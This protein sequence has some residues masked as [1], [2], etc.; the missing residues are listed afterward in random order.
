MVVYHQLKR[1]VKIGTY[2]SSYRVME[3]IKKKGNYVMDF[4]NEKLYV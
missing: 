2:T 3:V 1:N 4:M